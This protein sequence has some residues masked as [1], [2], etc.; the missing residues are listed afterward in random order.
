MPETKWV[1]WDTIG[2]DTYWLHGKILTFSTCYNSF[3]LP[4]HSYSH[5]DP[6]YLTIVLF[7]LQLCKGLW[8]SLA[9]YPLAGLYKLGIGCFLIVFYYCSIQFRLLFNT[10][11]IGRLVYMVQYKSLNSRENVL[12]Y[13]PVLEYCFSKPSSYNYFFI[14][15]VPQK[16]SKMF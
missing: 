6:V 15:K 4:K 11:E 5:L 9:H 16:N 2:P 1:C 12:I 14:V 8:F 7:F 10:V 13:V 3:R